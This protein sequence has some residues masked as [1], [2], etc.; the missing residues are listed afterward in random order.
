MTAEHTLFL[1]SRE[2]KWSFSFT[3]KGHT[4]SLDIRDHSRHYKQRDFLPELQVHGNF[5]E[6]DYGWRVSYFISLVHDEELNSALY[7]FDW[8]SMRELDGGDLPERTRALLIA[9]VDKIITIKPE[10]QWPKTVATIV[11]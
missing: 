6:G 8:S 1:E 7:T 5:A 11:E 4:C 9:L 3:H 10:R 2:V